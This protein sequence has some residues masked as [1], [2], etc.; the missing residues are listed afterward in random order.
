M[1]LWHADPVQ[2]GE[3]SYEEEIDQD[4]E[5]AAD[6]E[7]RAPK[8]YLKNNK[9]VQAQE[10]PCADIGDISFSIPF[11][12]KSDPAPNPRFSILNK[13]NTICC[14]S[15]FLT[16]NIFSYNVKPTEKVGAWK[17]WSASGSMGSFLWLTRKKSSAF[18]IRFS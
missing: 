6:R 13:K 14:V 10:G 18:S 2:A 5:H 3:F 7:I 12:L 8:G 9:T 17:R 15:F 1:L 16:Y 4:C 11:G